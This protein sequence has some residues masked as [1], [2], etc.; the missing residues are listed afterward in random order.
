MDQAGQFRILGN[1][2]VWAGDQQVKVAGLRLQR[3]LAVLL[4]DAGRIVPTS[5]I[6]DVL[7]D[8]EPPVTAR[9]QVHNTTSPPGW[10][11]H[12]W[13]WGFGLGAL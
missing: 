11:H 2:E 5:R 6:I 8:G 10:S 3:L 1:V 9:E 12:V 13:L 4:L 7:W